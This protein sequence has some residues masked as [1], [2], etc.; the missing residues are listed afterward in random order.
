MEG[1]AMHLLKSCSRRLI[2]VAAIACAAAL[3]TVA[4]SAATASPARHTGAAASAGTPSCAS[5]ELVVWLNTEGNGTAGSTYYNLELTNLSGHACTLFGYPGVSAINLAGKQLG[6][7][8]IRNNVG[9]SSTVKLASGSSAIV[10]LR[11]TDVDNF[12]S[13]ACHRVTAAGLRVYPP[14]QKKSELVPY[15]F[16]AC[17]RS[18]PTYLSVEAVKKA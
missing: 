3:A 2:G 13:T 10:V 5:S 16:G 12:P 17:S 8:A 18:G 9:P 15:P 7:A 14:N 6:S 11:I 4:V 1:T